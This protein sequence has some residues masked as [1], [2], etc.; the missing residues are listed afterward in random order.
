MKTK[1]FNKRLILNKKTI[2]DLRQA[3]M[4]E[5]YGGSSKCTGIVCPPDPS[6]VS[7][8]QCTMFTCTC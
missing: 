6:W 2:A 3:E 4:N 8:E 1:N 5:V 7:C